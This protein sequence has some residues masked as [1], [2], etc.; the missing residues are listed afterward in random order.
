MTGFKPN[1]KF[2]PD[3]ETL[4]SVM[5]G[6]RKPESQL[7]SNQIHPSTNELIS[8]VN[9][10][11]AVNSNDDTNFIAQELMSVNEWSKTSK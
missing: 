5:Y 4:R 11:F 6:N 7:K 8:K 3:I 10:I 1:I 2:Q 9:K